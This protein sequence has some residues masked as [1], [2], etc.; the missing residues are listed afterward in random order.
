MILRRV[1]S[2]SQ[3]VF[4]TF[5]DGPDPV[6]TKP[7]LEVLAKYDARATFFVI[8]DKA[9]REPTLIEEILSAGHTIGNHSADHAYRHLFR[10]EAHLRTWI[11]SADQG[12]RAQGINPVG[13]R[14]PAGVLTPHLLAAA[15][16]SAQPVVL[17]N[18]R[19]F[20]AVIPWGEARARR[21]AG[22]LKG[23]SIVLLH[24]R[25]RAARV[26]KFC[27]TLD[28]YLACLEQRGLRFEAL[29]NEICSGVQR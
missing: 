22:R 18:E 13:F 21:S 29:T 25:Q 11:E 9:K 28:T 23:G 10:G 26:N 19:F 20:D 8:T 27:K 7:V 17:W 5:D 4:L 24:D 3:S 16:A 12:L 15:R 2:H 1:K 14:P 6:G